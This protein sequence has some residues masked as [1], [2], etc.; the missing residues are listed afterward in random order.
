MRFPTLTELP[1]PPAG[2]TG[3]PWT[4]ESRPLLNTMSDGSPWPRI[5]VVTPSFNQGQLI[6]ETIRSVLLQGY[7]NLEYFVLDGGSTD[8]SIEIIQKYAPWLSY[9]ASEP[10]SGQSD[11]INR[12]LKMGSGLFATWINSDDMLCKDAIVN[13]ASRIGF[14]PNVVYVGICVRTD[15]DRKILFSRRGRVHSLEDL[16]RIRTV[17]RSGGHIVQPEVL[18]PLK[19]ALEVGGLNVDN[20]FTMDYEL[21]GKFFLAGARFQYTEIPFGMFRRYAEQKTHDGMRTTQALI[22]NASRLVTL[23]NCFSDETKKEILTD[24]KAYQDEYQKA[25]RKRAGLFRNSRSRLQKSAKGVIK[26]IEK[27]IC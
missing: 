24:L 9:W 19:L 16:V 22:D 5:T 6:E 26:L 18:F 20:H 11:A 21:W 1:S 2:K 17:W 4:E 25:Y 23:A 8:N 10:D 27:A 14:D 7:P 15:V 13:H 12:G 3:W